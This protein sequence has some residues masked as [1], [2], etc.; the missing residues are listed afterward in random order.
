M[1]ATR[2]RAPVWTVHAGLI[3]GIV[4]IS[5]SVWAAGPG[6]EAQAPALFYGFLSAFASAFLRRRVA[7]SY[8][9]IAG[10]MYLAALLSHWRA[11]MA[12][13]WATNMFAIIVPCVVI[14]TLVARL[15]QLALHDTLTGL[16]NRRLLE[17]ILT[18]RIATAQREHEPLSVAAIDLDGLKIVNDRDGHAAGDRLLKTAAHSWSSV[19]RSGDSLARTGGDEFVLVLAD[20]DLTGATDVVQRLRDSAPQV[21]FSAGV[22]LW[23]GQ[24][25]DDLLRRADAGLYAATKMGGGLTVVDP[26]AACNATLTLPQASPRVR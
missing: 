15:R 18:I 26:T 9:A 23:E 16:A 22:A 14:S 4:C 8:V 19:L 1:W 13:Q 12:T 7:L 21:A 24:N 11:E 25:I 3:V 5:A 6:A 10:T 20:T 2:R 17:E